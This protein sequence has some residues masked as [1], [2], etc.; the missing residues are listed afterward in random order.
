M[1]RLWILSSTLPLSKDTNDTIG[2]KCR[3]NVGVEAAQPETS[4]GEEDCAEITF[5]RNE[6]TKRAFTSASGSNTNGANANAALWDK[7]RSF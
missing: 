7:T 3:K 6:K 2:E 5:A 4:E 1:E